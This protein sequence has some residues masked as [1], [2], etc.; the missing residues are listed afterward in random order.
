MDISI[1]YQGQIDGDYSIIKKIVEGY[2]S[3]I[4]LVKDNK[5]DIEYVVKSYK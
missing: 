3:T 4:Y 5:T 2:F 1:D